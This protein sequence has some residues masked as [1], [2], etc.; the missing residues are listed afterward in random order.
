MA[1]LNKKLLAAAVSLSFL[2]IYAEIPEADIYAQEE[3]APADT[4]GKIKE[5]P[6]KIY[7]DTSVETQGGTSAEIQGGILE[8]EKIHP[9]S[10][11]TQEELIRLIEKN[12]GGTIYLTGDI[13]WDR[14]HTDWLRAGSETTIAM[15]GHSLIIEKNASIELIGPFHFTGKGQDKPLVVLGEQSGFTGEGGVTIDA[16]GAGCV[17]A[18]MAGTASLK[19]GVISAKGEGCTAILAQ[20]YYNEA[21]SISVY[22]HIAADG[23]NATAIQ[24]AGNL[25]LLKMSLQASGKNSAAV[26]TD[27]DVYAFFL[28][29][30]GR[31]L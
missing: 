26:R 1:C 4:N 21:N 2:I 7:K 9:E 13:Y 19:A 31:A 5:I 3:A 18:S 12:D 23:N 24:A 16:E 29:L 30:Q 15:N 11:S 10:C 25:N 28:S 22:G 6:P 17:A 8:E 20:G 27:G 14:P